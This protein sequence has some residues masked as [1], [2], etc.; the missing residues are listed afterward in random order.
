MSLRQLTSELSFDLLIKKRGQRGF[1]TE[2]L[3]HTEFMVD[4]IIEFFGKNAT[5]ECDKVSFHHSSTATENI[6]VLHSMI[7][8][9]H[10]TTKSSSNSV[11]DKSTIAN[12]KYC[13]GTGVR[14]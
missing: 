6:R 9:F 11:A 14:R 4:L 5:I 12:G 13:R 10:F 8:M 7:N 2:K 1:I 3:N